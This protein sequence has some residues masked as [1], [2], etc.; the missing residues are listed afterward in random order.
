[1]NKTSLK[2]E[3][4]FLTY[5]DKMGETPG[6][7]IGITNLKTIEEGNPKEIGKWLQKTV[8]VLESRLEDVEFQPYEYEK[9]KT[10]PRLKE[11]LNTLREMGKEM[12]N[13]TNQESKEY[14]GYIIAMT[15]DIISSLFN[16]IEIYLDEHSR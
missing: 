5:V 11:A 7:F 6:G 15:V 16:H 8:D 1:M 3:K 14:Y 10:R 13:R 12:E 9:G 2:L 4:L